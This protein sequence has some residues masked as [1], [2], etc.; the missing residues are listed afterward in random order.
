MQRT[1]EKVM[2]SHVEDR[3]AKFL[4]REGAKVTRLLQMHIER[5]QAKEAAQ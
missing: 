1:V 2:T 5:E 3:D 4:V